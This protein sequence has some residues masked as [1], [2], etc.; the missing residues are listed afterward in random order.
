MVFL[1]I[2]KLAAYISWD[3]L[4]YLIFSNNLQYL[5]NQ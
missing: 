1:L 2:K 5:H 4:T 3:D